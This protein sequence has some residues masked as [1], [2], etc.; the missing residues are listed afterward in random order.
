MRERVLNFLRE[1]KQKWMGLNPAQRKAYLWDYYRLPI[2]L[3]LVALGVAALVLISS[4]GRESY[5][6]HVVM[7]NAGEGDP[8]VLTGALREE[9]GWAAAD[10][11]DINLSL[12][13]Y[14]R[15]DTASSDSQTIQVLAALFAV[16]DM[17]LFIAD[18]DIFSRY[19]N[20]D[21]F[22]NL[23]VLLPQALQRTHSGLLYRFTNEQGQDKVAGVILPAGSLL[24][25]AGYYTSEV[26]IGIAAR[27]GNLDNALK[28]VQLL[29]ETL[30][31]AAPGSARKP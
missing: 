12:N 24:H 2:I 27:S 11:V 3:G 23:A 10:K 19:A 31:A 26:V 16:G 4:I 14:L 28:A 13:L 5:G 1:E 30:P 29:L 25:Q 8:L 22:E 17:D 9:G 15:D 21:A 7:L 6:M 18:R 20:Q